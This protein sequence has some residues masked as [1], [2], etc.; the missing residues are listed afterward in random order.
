[1]FLCTLGGR[2]RGTIDC[3]F[4]VL[5][6]MMMVVEEKEEKEEEKEGEEEEEA[7]WKTRR[8]LLGAAVSLGP[9][10]QARR[11]Q[12]NVKSKVSLEPAGVERAER[13]RKNIFYPRKI[14]VKI[15]PGQPEL[16]TPPP[17][18]QMPTW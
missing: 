9:A 13:S 12:V 3:I 11:G 5:L 1:M 7:A 6:V 15:L 17:L 14:K 16:S 4:P 10:R 8:K 2:E 18:T